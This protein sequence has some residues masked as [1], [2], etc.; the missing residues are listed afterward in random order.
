VLVVGA[1]GVDRA[2]VD[3]LKRQ[4]TDAQANVEGTLWL[5][6][7]LQLDNQGDADAVA[8]TLGMPSDK[9]DALR[10]Q[11]VSRLAA[12][13]DGGPNGAGVLPALRQAGFLGYDAPPQSATTTT[14]DPNLIPVPGTR[15]V[16]VSG[17]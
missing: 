6:R 4:L 5:T 16:V 9:P 12:A 14:I 17:A 11:V 15:V 2:P 7:K 1:A 3:D 8:S 13:L 10:P